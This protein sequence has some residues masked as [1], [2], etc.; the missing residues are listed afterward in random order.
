MPGDDYRRR[1]SAWGEGGSLA[2][3]FSTY[4]APIVGGF[5]ESDEEY[6]ARIVESRRRALEGLNIMERIYERRTRES[7][8]NAI[9]NAFD[10]EGRIREAMVSG[11]FRQAQGLCDQLVEIEDF[12][13]REGVTKSLGARCLKFYCEGQSWYGIAEFNDAARSFS[14][15]LAYAGKDKE[16]IQCDQA[17]AQAM[18]ELEKGLLQESVSGALGYL[19]RAATVLKQ[20]L[21]AVGAVRS[22]EMKALLSYAEGLISMGEGIEQRNGMYFEE[23]ANKFDLASAAMPHA[24][25]VMKWFCK[26]L[27]EGDTKEGDEAYQTFRK[28]GLATPKPQKPGPE[29]VEAF[30]F[31]LSLVFNW[32]VLSHLPQRSYLKSPE[33]IRSV[34]ADQRR[35]IE[36]TKRETEAKK[37]ELLGR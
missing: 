31:Q 35:F 21:A 13:L 20:C 23:A 34:A 4:V 19:N 10:L 6:N 12:L 25:R 3:V 1:I 15:A 33:V 28:T 2:D 18:S 16:V 9:A 24:A 26:M 32:E 17:K 11:E 22:L 27:A 8:Q 7:V 30:L 37:R 36:Q 14:K 5:E 29:M